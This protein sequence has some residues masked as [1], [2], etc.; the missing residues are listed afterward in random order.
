MKKV[1]F[2]L[3]FVALLAQPAFSGV[4][5]DKCFGTLDNDYDG[6][7]TKDEFKAAFPEGADAVFMAADGDKNGTISHDE[8]EEYKESQGFEDKHEDS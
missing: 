3:M 2:T 7:M 6:E 8:W 4:D 1:F 5:Y